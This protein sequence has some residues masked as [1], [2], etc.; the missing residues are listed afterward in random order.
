MEKYRAIPPGYMTVGELAKKMNTTV[1]TLQYYDKEG[2]FSPSAESDGG[3]R[4]YSDKDIITLHQI[5]SMK[6]LGFSLDDIKNR[7]I[8]LD[9]PEQ[10]AG[11]LT[12]QAKAI[13]EKIDSLSEA[14]AAVEKLKAETLQMKT[15]DFKKY[16]AIVSLLRMGNEDYWIVKHFDD[17]TLAHIQNRFDEESGKTVLDTLKRLCGEVAELQ[18]NGITPESE[19]GQAVAKAWWDMVMEFTGGDMSL[20]PE[21]VKFSENRD[22]MDEDFKE[23]MACMDDFVPKAMEVYFAKLGYNPFEGVKND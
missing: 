10:V 1:R 8:V 20:L 15:V 9:T 4:L 18:R 23:K 13:R 19:E 17:K 6:F 2:L 21:L 7:L 14:L 11:T 3:R 16:A 22:G 5:Q 12:E